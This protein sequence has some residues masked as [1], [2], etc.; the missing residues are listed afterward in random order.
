SH[1]FGL[2]GYWA[3]LVS[4]PGGAPD[5]MR[6]QFRAAVAPRTARGIRRFAGPVFARAPGKAGAEPA[7]GEVAAPGIHRPATAPISRQRSAVWHSK[8]S[9][10]RL[11]SRSR[12]PSARM[13]RLEQ[14]L[15]LIP[16]RTGAP[17]LLRTEEEGVHKSKLNAI[18]AQVLLGLND[19]PLAE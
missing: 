13:V 15:C 5:P 14:V 6:R 3:G 18:C 12:N 10:F 9:S 19:H 1:C 4:E 17:P 8:R 16:D 2:V 7:L 11:L